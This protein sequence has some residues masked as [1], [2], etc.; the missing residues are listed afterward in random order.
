MAKYVLFVVAMV[1]SV[2]VTSFVADYALAKHP[3][4]TLAP[5]KV[6]QCHRYD[7]ASHIARAIHP[8]CRRYTA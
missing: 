1:L 4:K 3:F 5:V 7:P 2:L 6:P 8:E